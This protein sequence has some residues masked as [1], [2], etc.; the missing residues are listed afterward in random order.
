DGNSYKMISVTAGI[1]QNGLQQVSSEELSK[2]S[3]LVVK[4]AYSLLMKV[5][6][7]G[8]DK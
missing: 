5:M 4:N 7:G 8:E 6:N 1:V 3:R 2:T